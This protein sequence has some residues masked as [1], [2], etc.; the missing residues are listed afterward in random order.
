MGIVITSKQLQTSTDIYRFIVFVD[1]SNGNEISL[2]KRLAEKLVKIKPSR[3]TIQLEK[4]LLSVLE[5][6]PDNSTIKDIDVLF[7]P[8][9]KIDVLR[10]LIDANKKHPFKV[11]WAGNYEDGRLIYSEE[12]L[13]DYKTY[14]INDYDIVCVV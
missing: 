8:E 14:E 7:N 1:H 2:S 12:G 5:D 3:R 13:A 4:C 10:L 9:Y 11:L 6:I